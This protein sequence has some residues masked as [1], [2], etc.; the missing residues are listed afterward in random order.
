[1][2][3]WPAGTQRR[4]GDPLARP[5]RRH[6]AAGRSRGSCRPA[7]A[8]RAG[9][10]AGQGRPRRRSVAHRRADR[11]DRS[12]PDGPRQ[13]VRRPVRRLA[14]ADADRR[15]GTP[16]GARPVDPRRADQSSRP[17][18]H[19]H[20]RTL[21]DPGLRRADADRQPRPR[22]PRPGDRTH[23]LPACRRRAF[24]QDAL[25]A[26]ARGAAA[27]R[28]HGRRARAAGGQGDQAARAGCGALQGLGGQEPRPQ[29]AQERRRESHRAHREGAHADLCRARAP[30][31]AGRLRHRRQGGAAA[32]RPRGEDARR[33]QAHEH[34]Q[35]RHRRR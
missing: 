19:Q 17:R 18:Q 23:A 5:A 8:R 3:W 25:L 1:M 20:A 32:G 6:P 21:A 15:G 13:A 10:C 35:A 31:R 9:R 12:R 26:G 4:P 16:G 24:L 29:Q 2:P 7:G 14:A 34:R 33:P 30:A 11:R 22:I 27:P 28:R